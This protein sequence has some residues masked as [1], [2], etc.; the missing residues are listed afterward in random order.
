MIP[1]FVGTPVTD[2]IIGGKDH[3]IQ[4]VGIS[5]WSFID[6]KEPVGQ[7]SRLLGSF[8]YIFSSSKISG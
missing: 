3:I 8:Y 1:I 5:L 6:K 7:D 2:V 4:K